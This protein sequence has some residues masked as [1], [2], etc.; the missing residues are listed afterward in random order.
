MGVADERAGQRQHQFPSMSPGLA[1]EFLDRLP[2]VGWAGRGRHGPAVADR[3][4][5][6]KVTRDLSEK[7]AALETE[8]AAP[9]IVQADRDD[10]GVDTFHDEF[11]AAPKRQHLPDPRDLALGKD[12]HHLA[13]ADQV[14]GVLERA[15][16][17]ARTLLGGDRDRFHHAGERLDQPVIVDIPEHHR[18]Q[19]AIG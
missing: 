15:D 7:P 14:A 9:D 17:L 8:D 12:H 19:H 3:D 6:R 16:H 11:H 1:V 13:L 5:V 2:H 18:S 10:R 4:R